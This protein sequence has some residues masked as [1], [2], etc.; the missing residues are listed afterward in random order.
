MP[1]FFSPLAD[2]ATWTLARTGV[3]ELPAATR[4]AG[5]RLLGVRATKERRQFL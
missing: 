3:I 1:G 5:Y 4:Y 2:P